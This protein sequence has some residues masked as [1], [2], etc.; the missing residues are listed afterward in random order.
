MGERKGV[1]DLNSNE[2]ERLDAFGYQI[3]TCYQLSIDI[4]DD[5]VDR[6]EGRPDNEKPL[7]IINDL[8]RME[9]D[10]NRIREDM[11]DY[12]RQYLADGGE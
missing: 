9:M 11:N 12:F 3:T 7:N 4:K 10:L 8:E 5:I 2:V 6:F 1:K